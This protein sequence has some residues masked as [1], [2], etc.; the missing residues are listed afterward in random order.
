MI[1]RVAIALV[2]VCAPA[3]ALA[4]DCPTAVPDDPGQRRQV[5]KRWFA[6]GESEAK[7]G[8]DLA[9]LKAYQCSISFVPHAFTAYNIGQ[10]A[11]R[12]GDLDAAI[13]SYD[14]Y[15]MLAPDAK[16]AKEI[17]ERVAVL[18][19]R[20]AKVRQGDKSNDKPLEKLLEKTRH[21]PFPESE[22]AGRPTLTEVPG[23]DLA[24]NQR[25]AAAYRTAAWI[26]AGG[27]GLLLVGGVVT[28][29]LA[30]RQM[31]TCNAEYAQGNQSAA[32]SACSNAKPLAYLSYGMLGVGTAAV[33]TGAVLRFTRSDAE[34]VALNLLPEGG[35]ALRWS[36]RY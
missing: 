30:R 5:A 23:A 35:L 21:E 36:G 6:K 19:E 18:K 24:L 8:N 11:E 15:L 34:S 13:T 22:L 20:L 25:R 17:G 7:G 26:T 12:I 31:D 27:G 3:A 29:L 1:N 10:M 2:V 9:A 33:V 14:Q 32:E 16:D 4:Q 28:N